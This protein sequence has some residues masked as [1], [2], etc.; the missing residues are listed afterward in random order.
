MTGR[1]TPFGIFAGVSTSTIG[2]ELQLILD[3]PGSESPRSTA[4]CACAAST[5]GRPPAGVASSPSAH[6]GPRKQEL[7]ELLADRARLE[8]GRRGRD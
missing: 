6:H 8:R 5:P 2:D 3:A 4:P 7:E 1:S